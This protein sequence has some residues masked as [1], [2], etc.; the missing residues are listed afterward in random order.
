MEKK[1]L[2]EAEEAELAELDQK[3]VKKDHV[4]CM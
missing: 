4:M 3:G 2:Q 1:A